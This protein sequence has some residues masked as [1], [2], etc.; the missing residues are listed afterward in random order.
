MER[1]PHRLFALSVTTP[2]LKL[3][4]AASFAG[5]VLG[6]WLSWKGSWS[7]PL[8]Y[9]AIFGGGGIVLLG[10]AAR[11]IADQDSLT[12]Q[13][14]FSRHTVLWSEISRVEVG[15]GNLVIHLGAEGRITAPS[16]EFWVGEDRGAMLTLVGTKLAEHG[17]PMKNSVRVLFQATTWKK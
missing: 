3:L 6:A 17:I 5:S 11:I 4:A 14:L 16:L 7:D 13:K 12:I 8:L 1:P 15:G 10:M 2:L 9:L